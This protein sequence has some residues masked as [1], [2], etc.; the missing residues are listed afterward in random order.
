MDAVLLVQNFNDTIWFLA[1]CRLCASVVGLLPVCGFEFESPVV[2]LTL[3]S[4]LSLA[5]P[6]HDGLA[7]AD[8]IQMLPVNLRWLAGIFQSGP[9]L[10]SFILSLS[11]AR[12]AAIIGDNTVT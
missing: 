3:D 7:T 11:Y 12:D 6:R 8:F 2:F 10:G 9:F 5:A 4:T 1:L